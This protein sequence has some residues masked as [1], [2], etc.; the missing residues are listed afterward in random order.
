MQRKGLG[1]GFTEAFSCVCFVL[2]CLE[3]G[4]DSPDFVQR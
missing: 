1:V 4:P 3:A 2:F